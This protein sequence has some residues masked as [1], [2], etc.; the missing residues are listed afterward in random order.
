[1]R[2]RVNR[3]HLGR[4]A[5]HKKALMSNLVRALILNEKIE[6]TLPKAK[7][8]RGFAERMIT[9]AK[10]GTLSGRREALRFITDK[11]AIKKLFDDIA[12]KYRDRK[13]GYTRIVKAGFRRGDA[14]EMA[15][16]ELV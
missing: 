7:E 8:M 2:H 15:I 3:R 16:I 6:T 4:T 13:G 10:T 12:P 5:T 11:D 9:F 1:M 14:A